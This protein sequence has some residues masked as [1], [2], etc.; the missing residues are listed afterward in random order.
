MLPQNFPNQL[1]DAL[2]QVLLAL[3]KIVLLPF[4]LWVRAITNLAEQKQNGDL[5]VQNIKGL[6]PFF[7]FVKRLFLD[8]LLDSI[9][10]LSYPIGVISAFGAFIAAFV[11]A[12]KFMRPADMIVSAIGAF[13]GVLFA[14]YLVPVITAYI[15]NTLQFLLLPV[16]K[17]VDWLKKPAQH[18]DLNTVQPMKVK[19]EE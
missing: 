2:M 3:L 17:F 9:A 18:L 12:P 14:S 16:Y 6:W 5:N 10:L 4:N 13:V 19:K 15:H 8:F 11:D 1:L 7:S